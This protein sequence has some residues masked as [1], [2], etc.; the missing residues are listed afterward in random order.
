MGRN[1]S[2]HRLNDAAS[3]AAEPRKG[4]NRLLEIRPPFKRR[5]VFRQHGDVQCRLEV[6]RAVAFEAQ[7]AVPRHPVQRPVVE[8]MGIVQKAGM[9]RVLHRGEAA[10]RLV[11]RLDAQHPQPARPR[12]AWRIRLLWPA[13]MMMPS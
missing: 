10:A 1:A 3:A 7:V 13:P 6:Y 5:A 2:R 12:Y 9:P 8:R 11:P 4:V